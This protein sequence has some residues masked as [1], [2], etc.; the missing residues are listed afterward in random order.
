MKKYL[1]LVFVW[2]RI[3]LG[4]AHCVAIDPLN[5]GVGTALKSPLGYVTST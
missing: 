3:V 2:F 5:V 1:P 4:I